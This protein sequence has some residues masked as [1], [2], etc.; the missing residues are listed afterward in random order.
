M[1]DILISTGI[2]REI[3]DANL[4][5]VRNLAFLILHVLGLRS[6]F[7]KLENP[8]KSRAFLM[9]MSKLDGTSIFAV[10]YL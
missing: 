7:V 9:G 6:P 8:A 5:D 1:L 10:K 3:W 4:V 2:L